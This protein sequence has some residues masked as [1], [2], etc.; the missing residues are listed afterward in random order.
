MRWSNNRYTSNIHR[1]I[2]T[3]GKDRYS[4]PFFLGGNPD[5]VFDCLPGCGD[6]NKAGSGSKYA[7]ISVKDFI[8]E[9]YQ[10]SYT[11]ST[12]FFI[13]EQQKIGCGNTGNG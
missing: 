4:I 9:Q 7:P 13:D 6:T 2:N 12:K 3:P 1:V 5:Y 11:K 8:A 10:M